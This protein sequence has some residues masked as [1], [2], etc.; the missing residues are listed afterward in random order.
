LGFDL[1]EKTIHQKPIS[2]VRLLLKA[3]G[4]LLLAN[5]VFALI[6]PLPLLG[7]ISIYNFL[8]PGRQRLPYG[9]DPQ[10]A[11][12]ISLYNLEAM[13]ASHELAGRPKP[14]DEFRVI[15]IG[16]SATWGYL[17]RNPDTLAGKIN[18]TQARLAD[19]RQV[20]AYNLGYPVMS[21]TKDLLL[22]FYA[23][24]YQPDLIVWPVTLESFPKDK[25]LFS[26]LLQNNPETVK[27]LLENNRLPVE[28]QANE[29][30]ET[31]WFER[32][33]IGARRSLADIFRLQLYGLLWAAT[34]IDQD[35]PENYPP[36]QE[37]LEADLSFHDLQQD[38][39]KAD[40]LALD[41]LEAG[42]K[43]AGGTPVL[44]VNEPMFISNG[45]NSDLRYN[46]YYPRWAYDEYRR[47]MS[48]Q[49]KEQGWWYLDLWNLTPASEFTNSAVHMTPAGTELF[50]KRI[51]EA[52]N[53][54]GQ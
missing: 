6:F 51:I 45:K 2:P 41:V 12:N 44:I 43:M 17:L 30:Q 27:K 49:S 18:A 23:L 53:Q 33:I 36:R 28:P 52:I 14:V 42:V 38:K 39:L 22:L 7:K 3:L 1:S 46:F 31:G 47:L 19:G 9:D 8:I 21:L 16:D 25:Q 37:D 29:W 50:A 10:K 24:K 4:L 26:P 32:T 5:L 34:G 54:A 13:F 20:R 40:D 48:D 35:I 11:Y 15:L